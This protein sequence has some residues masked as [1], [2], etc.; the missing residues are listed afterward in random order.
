MEAETKM[1]FN[2]LN[3]LEIIELIFLIKWKYSKYLEIS[4]VAD[5]ESYIRILKFK[6]AYLMRRTIIL[7]IN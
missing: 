2:F 5:N 7:K 3:S 4:R 6:M 1:K